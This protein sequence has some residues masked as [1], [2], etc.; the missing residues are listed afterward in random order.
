VAATAGQ[1]S[2]CELRYPGSRDGPENWN[3]IEKMVSK[4]T[5]KA[6]KQNEIS[7]LSLRSRSVVINKS[8]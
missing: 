3:L 7:P 4:Q 6:S 5:V 2:S 8:G 1:K